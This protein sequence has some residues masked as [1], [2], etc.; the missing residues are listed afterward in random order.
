[1]SMRPVHSR[2]ERLRSWGLLLALAP[3]LTFMGHWPHSLPIPGTELFVAVP[4]AGQP[5]EP[6]EGAEHSHGQHCH[7]DS[8]GCSDVPAAASPGFAL[9]SP[10]ALPSGASGFLILLILLSWQ[11]NNSTTIGPELQPPRLPLLA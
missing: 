7:G 4:L 6:G 2:K 3:M 9:L 10:S 11:P 5:V 8:E 1:M